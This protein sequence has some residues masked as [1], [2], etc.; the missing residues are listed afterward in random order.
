MCESSLDPETGKS[1]IHSRVADSTNPQIDEH[2]DEMF[3]LFDTDGDNALSAMEFAA[4]VIQK[5]ALKHYDEFEV[6]KEHFLK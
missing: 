1:I 3:Q 4:H 6:L 5:V 2:T